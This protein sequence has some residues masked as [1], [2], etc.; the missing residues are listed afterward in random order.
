VG[1]I[2]FLEVLGETDKATWALAAPSLWVQLLE[3]VGCVEHG[4]G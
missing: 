4:G 1:G 2:L 3:A